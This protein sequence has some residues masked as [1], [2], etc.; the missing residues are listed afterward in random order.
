V[1]GVD[2]SSLQ[3]DSQ[4]KSIDLPMLKIH[5]TF[6]HFK[7]VYEYVFFHPRASEAGI[8]LTASVRVCVCLSVRANN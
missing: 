2:N 8:V 6:M 1:Q 7:H 3:A 4:P 5:F